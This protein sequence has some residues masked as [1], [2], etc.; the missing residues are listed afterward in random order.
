MQAGTD[1]RTHQHRKRY[2]R[3]L[4]AV[5][6]LILTLQ[7]LGA[8]HHHHAY[9]DTRDDCASCVLAHHLP[10]DLPP[11]APALVM[12]LAMTSYPLPAIAAYGYVSRHSYLIP[13]AQAPP[14]A[15]PL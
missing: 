15:S 6:L 4:L 5:V 13:H 9:A 7:L 11:V 3:I 2:P 8:T 1:N 10:S 12:M 14:A